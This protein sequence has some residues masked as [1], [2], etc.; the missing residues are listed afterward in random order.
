MRLSITRK[1]KCSRNFTKF[2]ICEVKNIRKDFR[3]NRYDICGRP[4]F[5]PVLFIPFFVRE[6]PIIQ[7]LPKFFWQNF[8]IFDFFHLTTIFLFIVNTLAK[9]PFSYFRLFSSFS[10]TYVYL[11]E[12]YE[13]MLKQSLFVSSLLS[14]ASN[15]SCSCKHIMLA[16]FLYVY[17]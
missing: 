5:Q 15:N 14:F 10:Y 11:I 3:E 4:K 7:T 1:S 9:S 2:R 6:L 17:G 16:H 8:K 12:I 13:K